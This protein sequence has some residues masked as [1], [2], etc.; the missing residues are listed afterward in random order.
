LTS[1]RQGS[2]AA[3]PGFYGKSPSHGDFLSRRMPAGFLGV[4]DGWLQ[5]LLE[6]SRAR[7]GAAWT[8]R[9][10]AAPI[11]HFGLGPG[12]AGPAVH[13][14]VL[15]PSVDRV[16]RFFPFT[17]LGAA[18][19]DGVALQH[20]A[21]GAE[22]LILS[23]LEDGFA[24]PEL[25]RQLARLGQP[26]TQ[27]AISHGPARQALAGP[28]LD[29]PAD[30]AAAGAPGAGSSLWWSRGSDQVAGCLLRCA[31]LPGPEL[32]AGLVTGFD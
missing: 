19:P 5:T 12:I 10:L 11:W 8:E 26:A 24:L 1:P 15:I 9:W 6:A 13:W 7:L 20:W 14:G 21:L 17:I 28:D 29:W 30:V 25:E 27:A 23:T 32:A 16:G 22:A 4:W 31:G 2:F 3:P 18:A